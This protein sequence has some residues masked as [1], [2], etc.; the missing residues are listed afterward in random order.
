MSA[1]RQGLMNLKVRY[2]KKN[3]CLTMYVINMCVML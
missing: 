1:P 2:F 3:F